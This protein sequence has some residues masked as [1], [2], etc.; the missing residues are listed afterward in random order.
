MGPV[1][2]RASPGA[3]VLPDVLRR[4]AAATVLVA[5]LGFGVLAARYGGES[6]PGRLD[7]A[8]DG[9]IGGVAA[10]RGVRWV[11]YHVLQFGNPSSV[12]LLAVLLAGVCFVLRRPWLGLL[13]VAGP[14]LTGVA[15]SLLK[16]AIGRTLEGGFA[17]PSGHTGGATSLALV[18][19]LLLLSLVRVRVA[20]AA[21]LLAA[22]VVLAGG[23]MGVAMSG[24]GLH[25]PTDTIGGFCTAVVVVL[26]L[27]LLFQR[28][29]TR[30]ARLGVPEPG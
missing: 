15:T 18:S 22:G 5:A 2:W 28:L 20:P 23:T 7:E 21:G 27:A 13:A 9:G 17:Y 8:L 6:E 29:A 24:L 12:I 11:L 3:P 14:G 10:Q 25:Y 26:T 16:P 19:A 4:P 1:L 30:L